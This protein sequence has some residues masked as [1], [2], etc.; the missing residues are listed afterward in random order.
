MTLFSRKQ[1]LTAAIIVILCIA[2]LAFLIFSAGE[3]QAAE[4][5]GTTF[6][7]VSAIYQQQLGAGSGAGYQF[8]KS[9]VIL[10]GQ[11]TYTY[12]DA[13]TGTSSCR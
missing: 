7:A 6:L 11:A 3:A 5:R 8:G 1:L 2:A 9:G 12:Q 13:I 4:P 10:L